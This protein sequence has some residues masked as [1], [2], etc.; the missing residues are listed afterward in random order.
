MIL[1]K[2]VRSIA[3]GFLILFTAFIGMQTSVC[4]SGEPPV[5]HAGGPYEGYEC[6]SFLFNAENS[7][8]PEGT[9]LEYR[10]NFN[11]AWTEWSSLPYAEYRWLDDFSGSVMLEVTDGDLI[12]NDSV[13]VLVM[14]VAPF[15]LSIDVPSDTLYATMETSI[16]VHCF[17]GDLREGLPSLDTCTAVFSWGDGSSTSYYV[18]AGS[19]TSVGSHSYTNAGEYEI[20]VTLIDDEGESSLASQ[21]IVVNES[22]VSLDTLKGI[23]LGLEVPKRLKNNLLSKL[24]NIPRLLRQNRIHVVI[25]TLKAF[26]HFVE[27]QRGKKLS[28][29]DA[30]DLIS[31]ARLLIVSLRNR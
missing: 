3:V 15:I 30:K 22:A 17:D 12:S 18:E 20:T 16:T 31:T 24:D 7:Y 25:N 2:Q 1:K 8:D 4:A 21:L 29:A 28:R 26:I 19:D 27:A 13:E 6:N 11:G 10:W 23:I 14:N 9:P 5:A